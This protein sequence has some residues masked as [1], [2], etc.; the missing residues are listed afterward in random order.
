MTDIEDRKNSEGD[1]IVPSAGGLPGLWQLSSLPARGI[2]AARTTANTHGRDI[3]YGLH[4]LAD[5]SLIVSGHLT[6]AWGRA[7]TGYLGVARNLGWFPMRRLFAKNHADIFTS[8]LAMVSSIPQLITSA[9][10]PET[11]ACSLVVMA[12]TLRGSTRLGQALLEA[13]EP[14][15]N[16]C[17]KFLKE[18]FDD[19]AGG[20]LIKLPPMMLAARAVMQMTDGYMR[21]DYNSLAAGTLFLGAAVSIHHFDHRNVG[22]A[23]SVSPSSGPA[24]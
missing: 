18:S 11:A 13:S 12:Y 14:P 7:S 16:S 4:A 9:T 8:Y 1:R 24:P 6:G 22:Q 23:K 20:W 10:V 19:S 15:A 17:K 2:T 21:Q 3:Y 5:I